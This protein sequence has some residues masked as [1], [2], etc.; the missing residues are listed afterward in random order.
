MYTC[1]S[2]EVSIWT[3]FYF[4]KLKKKGGGQQQVNNPLLAVT[5]RQELLFELFISSATGGIFYA[6]LESRNVQPFVCHDWLH[7][8]GCFLIP[9]LQLRFF[10]E[11]LSL[12]HKAGERTRFVQQFF[13]SPCAPF[14][15]LNV[16]KKQKRE[17]KKL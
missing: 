3:L 4:L 7:A 8:P 14:S 10:P 16:S 15:F 5:H 2:L 1:T 13:L 11:T 9:S 6:N 17:T 12:F